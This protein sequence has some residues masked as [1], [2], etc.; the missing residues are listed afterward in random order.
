[1]T[2]YLDPRSDLVF[3][4]IFG[5]NPDLAMSF[6]NALMPL[7]PDQ[8]IV[9]LSYL[10]TEMVPTDAIQKRNSI[11]DVRCRDNTGRQFLVEMQM[12][13][14]EGFV[15]RMVFNASKA[16]TRQDFEAG[17]YSMLKNVYALALINDIFD[18][19]TDE[20]YHL[21]EI[22]NRSNPKEKIEDMEFVLVELPKFTPH[23]MSEKKMAALW[24]RFLNETKGE[25]D[26]P[27]ELEENPEISK[28]LQ[29]CRESAF[30]TA[31]LYAYE[32]FWDAVYVEKT[33]IYDAEVRGRAEGIEIGEKRG[34]QKKVAE[35]ILNCKQSGLS[36][37][38]IA[39]IVNL[40]EDE[41]T[42]TLTNHTD[43]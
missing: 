40:S 26:I 28:A 32:T 37:S 43:S 36:I 7:R 3:K 4:R 6:L 18:H 34:E 31:E 1:M 21:Y 35:I 12:Y 10:P 13:W 5:E 15:K 24:L 41:V 29:M 2:R 38:Q 19:E 33:R 30:S 8:Q 14:T 17:K 9:E 22:I 27:A 23:T 42:K 16:Y 20:F 11:V 39:L 25:H